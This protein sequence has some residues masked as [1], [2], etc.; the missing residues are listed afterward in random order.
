MSRFFGGSGIWSRFWA[1]QALS[2]MIPVTAGPFPAAYWGV[3]A[4]GL[5]ASQFLGF[6]VVFVEDISPSLRQAGESF[7]D[8]VKRNSSNFSMVGL[9]ENALSAAG[10]ET[11]ISESFVGNL[12]AGNDVTGV[13]FV[14]V[15]DEETAEE[16]L[17]ASLSA[18]TSM[19]VPSAVEKPLTVGGKSGVQRLFPPRGRPPQALLRVTKLTKAVKAAKAA[20][21]FKGAVDLGFTGALAIACR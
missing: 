9:A 15:G 7:G 13:A 21:L 14:F 5:S 3:E 11:G 12:L 17:A 6:L 2:Q 8:C 16:S 1:L 4:E 20:N 19:A 18:S 10:V